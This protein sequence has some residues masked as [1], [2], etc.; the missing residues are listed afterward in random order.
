[1]DARMEWAKTKDELVQVIRSMGYPDELGEMIAKNL[2][3]PKAMR[4]FIAYLYSARPRSAEEIVDEMLAIQSE[5]DLW[6]KKK[7]SEE[8]NRAYNIL[9]NDGLS[10]DNDE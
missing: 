2:G 5:I 6:R 10:V 8:A 3:S 4:R 7:E 9:L 1:M